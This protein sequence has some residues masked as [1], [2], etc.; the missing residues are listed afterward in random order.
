MRVIT[1]TAGLRADLVDPRRR[2]VPFVS[3]HVG[4]YFGRTT[5]GTNLTYSGGN[6]TVGIDIR[7]HA[8]V[9]ARYDLVERNT[10]GMTFR[11]AFKAF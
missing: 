10:G 7:R 4:P 11:V 9:S 5:S 8:I 2:I 6:A 1:P 3:L